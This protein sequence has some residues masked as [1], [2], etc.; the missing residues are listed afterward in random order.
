MLKIAE[1]CAAIWWAVAGTHCVLAEELPAVDATPRKPA[2]STADDAMRWPQFRGPNSSPVADGAG[3]PDTWSA[4]ENVVWK[5]E[6]PGRGWS[7]P[8][9][10]AD[11]VFLTTA[12]SSAPVEQP[13]KGIYV[14]GARPD[15]PDAEYEWKVLCLDLAT[16]RTDWERTVHRGKP[17]SSIHVKNTY[18][19]ETPATDGRHVYAYFGNVGIFCLT[20]QGEPVWEQ[21]WGVFPMQDGMG[22]AASPVLDG[23]RLYVVNDNDKQSYLAALDTTSGKEV[24]RAA[25]DDTSNWA[26]PFVW[27]NG[28]RTE[29]IVSGTRKVCAYDVNGNLSWQLGG[30]S[31]NAVPTPFAHEGLLYVA[32]GHTLAR[33]KPIVAVRPGASGDITLPEGSDTGPYIA[34][35]QKSASPYNP[36]LLGY[37]NHVYSLL[38]PGFLCCFDATTGALVYPKRRIPEGRSFTAS[39]WAYDGKVFC[40]N[41]DGV[42]FVLD[43]GDEFK[44]LRTNRLAEDDMC[45]ATPGFAGDKLLIRSAVRLYCIASGASVAK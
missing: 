39:P 17:Q 12:V 40:L 45:L 29:I 24:W 32:S 34:W 5:S 8:I 11:R 25:R 21:R 2:S 22:T 36:S 43:A 37:R 13:K 38:D 26:S 31:H 30:M 16:G 6:I 20:I 10:W 14:G 18:A 23:D 15:P 9:V 28:E 1:A 19:S 41:E 44:L 42:T 3:L 4:T 7:C 27:R 33:R 35:C